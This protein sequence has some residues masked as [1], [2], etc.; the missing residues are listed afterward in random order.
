[1]FPYLVYVVLGMGPGALCIRAS[2]LLTCQQDTFN[3]I[4]G[5]GL[6]IPL[7]A[8]RGAPGVG[9]TAP[10]YL[11]WLCQSYSP[12]AAG[13]ISTVPWLRFTRQLSSFKDQACTEQPEAA[14]D[15]GQVGAGAWG[16]RARKGLVARQ[17]IAPSCVPM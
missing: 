16:G 10:S 8:Y 6:L 2:T 11:V 4:S 14:P 1:M 3:I 15:A 13:P 17:Q 7:T 5:T 9:G 12:G